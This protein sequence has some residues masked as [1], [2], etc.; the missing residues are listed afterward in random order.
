MSLAVHAKEA[1]PEEL[2]SLTEKV[3]TAFTTLKPLID[4]KNWD[5]ALAILK[6][7]EPAAG[8]ESY[9][10]AVILDTEAKIYWQGKNEPALAI[11][12]WEELLRLCEK[13]P[14]YLEAKDR[15]EHMQF[16][17][18][19]YYMVASDPKLKDDAKKKQYLDKS[20]S[21]M[22]NWLANTPKPRQEDVLFYTTLLYY[23]AVANPDKIDMPVLHEARQAAESG[24]LIDAHPKEQFYQLLVVMYQQE[25]DFAK[26]AEYLEFMAAKHP[27]KDYFLQLMAIYNNIAA[28]TDKDERQQRAYYARAI[29]AVERAQSLGF[30]K[31]P[32]D[33]YNL[34]SMYNQVGQFGKAIDILYSGLKN[35]SIENTDK[36]WQV[37]AYF[38]QQISQPLQA[39]NVLKEA[40][41]LYPKSGEL[42]RQIADIYYQMDDVANVYEYCKRA[43]AKGNLSQKAY[44]TYQLLAYTAFELGKF[45]EAL[46]ACDQ[47]IKLGGPKELLRLKQGIQDAIEQDKAVKAAVEGKPS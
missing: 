20:M 32:K 4:A 37:L 33:N 6:G 43:V 36:N 23:K 35:G 21:Y 9:D 27:V 13:H 24:L 11:A 38:Y 29:N 30:I 40:E 2:P 10:R 17:A 44:T 16:L 3:S 8:P 7:L 34:V 1:P 45:P 26:A 47:A 25:G 12:P 14:L 28:S 15:I 22:K 5:G 46:D 31:T 39:I 41:K 42:D 19:T 18:Q